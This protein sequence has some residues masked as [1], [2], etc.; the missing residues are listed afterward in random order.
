MTFFENEKKKK[1]N[2]YDLN[3]DNQP[4]LTFD[5]LELNTN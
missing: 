3:Y 4:K 5:S 1:K 2:N